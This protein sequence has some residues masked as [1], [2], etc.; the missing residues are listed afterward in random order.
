MASLYKGALQEL[1]NVFDALND[2]D[3]DKALQMVVDAEKIVVFGGKMH[4][5]SHLAILVFLK[6][7]RYI[8]G[9]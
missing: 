4:R 3:V 2:S 8:K 5:Q 9:T 7:T 6:R 1:G